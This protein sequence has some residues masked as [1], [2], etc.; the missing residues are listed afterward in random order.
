[1]H[2]PLNTYVAG[3]E[4]PPITFE[5][6]TRHILALYCGAS[7][8]HNPLHTDS[9]FAREQAGLPDVIGHGMLSM[10]MAARVLSSLANPRELRSF[11]VRFLGMTQVHDRLTCRARIADR[12]CQGK[13][14][15]Y[16]IALSLE[17]H[18]GRLVL[19]GEAEVI[20]ETPEA[21]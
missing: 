16:V 10:A 20:L 8:D 17:A 4:L 2:R 15:R 9:D 13:R 14:G 5:P 12:T 11:A 7:G 18:D 1:M 21:A 6:I 3:D 19:R